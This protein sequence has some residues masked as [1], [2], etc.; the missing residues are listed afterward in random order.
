MQVHKLL[1]TENGVNP[2]PL[3]VNSTDCVCWIWS[4]QERYAIQEITKPDEI[5]N[6]VKNQAPPDSR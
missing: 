2:D 4:N 1:V 5:D 6:K 3:L